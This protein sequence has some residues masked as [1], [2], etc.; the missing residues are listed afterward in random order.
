MKE[1]RSAWLVTSVAVGHVA[2]IVFASAA[3]TCPTADCSSVPPFGALAAGVAS[4]V[5]IWVFGWP[6]VRELG[7]RKFSYA[8]LGWRADLLEDQAAALTI[9]L[10]TMSTAQ[11]LLFASF[12]LGLAL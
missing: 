3:V 11:L 4:S 8:L 6:R 5:G 7:I 2:S 9:C 10:R 12:A 1:G